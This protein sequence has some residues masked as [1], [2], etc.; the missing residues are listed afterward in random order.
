MN[1]SRQQG[2]I[3]V[4]P[5]NISIAVIGCGA[6]GS[7]VCVELTKLGLTYDVYDFDKVEA[8]NISNQ[9]FNNSDIGMYKVD[10]IDKWVASNDGVPV[11]VFPKAFTKEMIKENAYQYV[12]MLV[13]DM[14][15]RRDLVMEFFMNPNT[16]AVIET[17]MDFTEAHINT[18]ASYKQSKTWLKGAM[19]ENV[20]YSVC[21][22]KT[23]VSI[24]SSLISSLAV[25]Q[26]INLLNKKPV[27]ESIV[28]LME[29]MEVV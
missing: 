23:S 5:T 2:L 6:V 17:R 16:K 8:H 24:T 9:S 28:F 13:D 26:L 14:Q 25:M 22:S 11:S 21:G 3:K 7:K 1:I 4:L 19:Y 29:T 12:F 15:T 20:E 27:K 10:A 18:I